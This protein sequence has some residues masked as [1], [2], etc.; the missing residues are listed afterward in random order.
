MDGVCVLGLRV[1]FVDLSVLIVGVV[2][3]RV[4]V[5][6]GV[7]YLMVVVEGVVGLLVVVASAMGR[8]V[9]VDD[10]AWHGSPFLTGAQYFEHHGSQLLD[11]TASRRSTN[12]HCSSVG[13]RHC[14]VRL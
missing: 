14:R 5:A 1:I 9:A 8:T 6:A 12:T 2:G 10:L 13:T 11:R 7:M 4:V 3:R